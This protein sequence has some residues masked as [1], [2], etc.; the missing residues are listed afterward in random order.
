MLHQGRSWLVA[1]LLPFASVALVA[2]CN[3]GAKVARE[4]GSLCADGQAEACDSLGYQTL[5]GQYVLRDWSRASELFEAA[6]DAEVARGCVRLGNMLVHKDAGPNGIT[7]DSTMA[8]TLLAKGCDTGA[9][10][11]CADLA[12]MYAASKSMWPKPQICSSRPVMGVGCSA[13]LT[14]VMPTS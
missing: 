5:R 10:T 12:D 8:A 14:W 9:M 7:P 3:P 13:A 6:C 11:G 2:A 4:L 1:R